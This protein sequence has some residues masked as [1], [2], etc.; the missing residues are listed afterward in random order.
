MT[1]DSKL[2][3]TADDAGASH[4][5]PPNADQR[6]ARNL[7]DLLRQA[8]PRQ[9]GEKGLHDGTAARLCSTCISAA[10]TPTPLIE[11]LNQLGR[12]YAGQ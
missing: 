8:R 2:L 7:L 1:G 5:R 4:D 3:A 9:P 10:I 6:F 12:F 11:V